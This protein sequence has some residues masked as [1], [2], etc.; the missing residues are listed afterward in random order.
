MKQSTLIIMLLFAAGSAF[1]QISVTS[2]AAVEVVRSALEYS[3][4]TIQDPWDMNA[5]TD[6]S[7]F[8]FDQVSG[9]RSNLSDISFSSS[10][11][12][13]KATSADPNIY[14]LET[15][16]PG[17]CNLGRTG[18]GFPIDADTYTKLAMR[19][20]LSADSI[21][22]FFWSKGTIYDN[23]TWSNGFSTDAGWR[24]Y[25]IDLVALG[26]GGEAYG[27]PPEPWNGTVTAFRL[28]PGNSQVDMDIDWIKLVKE[29]PSL[30]RSVQ[31]TGAAGNVDIYLDNDQNAANGCL[32]MV[33][34]NIS[35]NSYNLYVGALSPET[36]YYVGVAEH[37][38]STLAY[39]SGYFQVNDIPVL[40]FI[41][42][43]A[44]GGEDFAE[45]K[46]GDGWDM[47]SLN[48]IDTTEYITN[49]GIQNVSAEDLEGNSLGSVRV[50]KGTSVA[51]TSPAVGDPM[52]FL[53]HENFRGTDTPIESDKYRILVLKMGLPGNWD[54][55]GGSVARVVWRL[56]GESESNV[57][58]DIVVRHKNPTPV[59]N[60]IIA[61]MKTLPLEEG[62]GSPSHSGWNGLIGRF[63]IDPHE[64]SDPKDF[65]IQSVKL[66]A[67]ERA[68]ATYTIRWSYADNLSTS[69][70]LAFYYDTDHSGFDGVEIVSGLD[71]NSGEY[72][73]NTSALPEGEVHIYA[74]YSDGM[75]SN[76]TYAPW[77]IVVEHAAV[78][79]AILALNR[80][81]LYFGAIQGFVH[82][83]PQRILIDNIGSG[84]MSW[85]A[86][87]LNDWVGVTPGSGTNSGVV[88]ISI[89]PAGLSVGNHLG[90]VRIAADEATNS[91]LVITV[92]TTVYADMSSTIGPWGTMD[93]PD[94][95]AVVYGNIPVSGWALDEIEVEQVQIWRDPISGE[96]VHANGYVYVGDAVFVE[97]A[98]PDV[99]TAYPGYPLNYRAGWGYMLL[100]NFLPN[101]GNG[102]FVLRAIATDKEGRTAEIGSKWIVADNASAVK[103]FGTIDTPAQG[104]VTSGN[105]Y[106][107]F[108]WA[109]T[110]Q[111]NMIPTDG[112]TITV[113]L[114]S[115][116]LAGHV[117][118]NHYRED[119]A[120]L[121]P[122]YANSNGAVGF[123]VLDTTAYANGVHNI[124]WSVTDN[125]GN[126]DGIGSRFFSIVNT[127]APGSTSTANT[128]QGMGTI[129]TMEQ[130]KMMLPDLSAV[131]V[132]DHSRMDGGRLVCASGEFN[133][134]VLSTRVMEGVT[135]DLNPDQ[136]PDARF[137]GYL[138]V[139]D[140]LRRL[141]IGSTLDTQN[142]TFYW[143]PGPGFYGAYDLVFID[144]NH[145]LVK[146]IRIAVR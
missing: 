99:E 61:D 69:A 76:R 138:Q 16:M 111:P 44:E 41:S 110:P 129:P 80:D 81:L 59:I 48:D 105:S 101:S 121:F 118:Y 33:A 84:T 123:Y 30:Y 28:D 56:L 14:I 34:C 82:T 46:L 79:E 37:G 120:T 130:L 36:I 9:S 74:V 113:W 23:F 21:G 15:P 107:N 24:Y 12:S 45:V 17:T 31:W 25:L 88:E 54:L 85:T 7:W 108:G 55:V 64:F 112:S 40:S 60:A 29:E 5:R 141:P 137:S 97:G 131:K 53:L 140:E 35:G 71:P 18:A 87:S 75:N 142:A 104:G 83:K 66:A 3:A 126:T 22:Q 8:V 92:N 145:K 124:A 128:V 51:S 115:V 103:P 90:Y 98:R 122:G 146:R 11:F 63:R 109:L 86:T 38:S 144:N 68:D 67:F 13:A 19:M 116:P 100:T 78:G 47:D 32:G 39:S 26:A 135:V 58:K 20:K 93:I 133:Q 49:L 117:N 65:Y 96:P 114:N 132:E 4:E 2:P 6:F 72:T 106:V 43:G 62:A 134:V 57:S 1:A 91:P 102:T 139:G 95:G 89:N 143:R 77:P 94:Q 10:V 27:N 42:P 73:W 125:D 70:T 52:V 127:A 50:L 136:R 119:I